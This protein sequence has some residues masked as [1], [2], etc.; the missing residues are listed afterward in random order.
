MET[1]TQETTATTTQETTTTQQ[2]APTTEET[3]NGTS[4]TCHSTSYN[5]DISTVPYQDSFRIRSGSAA[6]LIR[7]VNSM[8]ERVSADKETDEYKRSLYPCL[9]ELATQLVERFTVMLTATSQKDS[10]VRRYN[11]FGYEGQVRPDRYGRYPFVR[12][13]NPNTKYGY[14][15]FGYY[16][17]M[18]RQRMEFITLREMP[19][20]YVSDKEQHDYFVALRTQAA[21]YLDY[22]NTSVEQK[23]NTIV[24][25]ARTNGGGTVQKN[26][27]ERQKS[28]TERKKVRQQRTNRNEKQ[29]K[30]P[31]SKRFAMPR[32]I[33]KNKSQA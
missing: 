20:R 4:C 15:N 22:I 6:Q 18:L 7:G 11:L 16:V 19:Q 1:T 30:K 24:Q 21:E 2:V 17:K 28:Q 23:W 8:L 27:E 26:L 3:T 12:G 13:V 32:W 31:K 29:T 5:L 33:K 10:D 25:T 14:A 9:R